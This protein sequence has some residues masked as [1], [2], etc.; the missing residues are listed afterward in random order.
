MPARPMCPVRRHT[1]PGPRP[2]AARAL[3]A[4]GVLCAGLLAVSAPVVAA[5]IRLRGD[6]PFKVPA[7]TT[8]AALPVDAPLRAEDVRNGAVSFELS[9]DDAVGDADPDPWTGRY[10]RA[11]RAFRVRIG[12]TLLEMPVATARLVV[13]DGG[14]GRMYRESV[15]F[16]A[17]ARAGAFTVQAGWV[18]LNQAA[19]TADLRGAAGVIDGDRLPVAGR[20]V[21]FPTSGEFDRVFYVRIDAAGGTGR[22]LLYL[23]TS[24]LTVSVVAPGAPAT[25]STASAISAAAR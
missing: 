6:A 21:A 13:S 18:Q 12:D 19:L 10:D 17:D 1:R 7:E 4:L 23:S 16:V 2:L 25:P 3:A 8:L 5:E 24:R 9:Y 14:Q 11:I 15:E 20:L 22:P